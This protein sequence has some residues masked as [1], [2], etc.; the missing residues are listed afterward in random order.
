MHPVRAVLENGCAVVTP[1]IIS[2][3][4]FNVDHTSNNPLGN[5][6]ACSPD[7]GVEI[8]G[9]AYGESATIGLSSAD[10]LRSL[11]RIF[12]ERFFHE[13]M[14]SSL[15][16]LQRHVKMGLRRSSNVDDIGMLLEQQSS[17]VRI[18]DLETVADGELLRHER[19]AIAH[20]NELGAG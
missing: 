11:S 12:G 8:V 14:A 7:G 13:Q 15:N 4:G 20:S 6:F 1:E 5:A 3:E 19:F 9:P 10:Q 16:R 18:P 17:E 2:G